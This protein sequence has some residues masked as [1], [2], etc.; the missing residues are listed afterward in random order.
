MGR[1]TWIVVVIAVLYA[2]VCFA[3]FLAQARLVWFP[4]PP[5]SGTPRDR[6]LAYDEWQ[7]TASDGVAIH[8]WRVRTQSA[9]GAIILCHGNGGNIESR[10]EKAAVLVSLGFDV[11]LFDYR[12]YGSSAGA[13][14]EEGTYLDAEAVWSALVADGVAPQTI[15]LFGESL[16]GAVAIELARRRQVA[17]VIVEDTFTSLADMAAKVYPWL[18][19]RLILR[20]DYNSLAKVG[21]LNAPLF[22]IHSRADELVPFEHGRR[23][24]EAAAEPKQFLETTGTHNS[25]GFLSRAEWVAAVQEFLVR[26]VPIP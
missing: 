15:V 10:L 24:F 5:T 21:S 3:V 6:G 16:G 11:V 17:A 18:P 13:P 23:L 2:L 20:I 14:S 4:G 26:H 22:V 7:L 19:V 12:G 9:R 8:A 25:P 1:V